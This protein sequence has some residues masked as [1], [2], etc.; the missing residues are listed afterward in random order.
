MGEELVGPERIGSVWAKR[1]AHTAELPCVE[2]KSASRWQVTF[3][4][5]DGLRQGLAVL[6]RA[7]GGDPEKPLPEL[8]LRVGHEEQVLQ[9]EEEKGYWRWAISPDLAAGAVV[10]LKIK[11]VA[12]WRGELELYVQGTG[13]GEENVLRGRPGK[14]VGEEVLPPRP[15]EPGVHRTMTA[16]GSWPVNGS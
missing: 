6:L 15:Y 10:E 11:G 3:P 13:P 4:S 16:L 5:A 1:S 9:L 2:R 12:G 14:S 7:E 8:R